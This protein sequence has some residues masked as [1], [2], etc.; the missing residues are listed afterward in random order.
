[1]AFGSCRTTVSCVASPEV[2]ARSGLSWPIAGAHP[3]QA[4]SESC[5]RSCWPDGRRDLLAWSL[6][7]PVRHRVPPLFSLPMRE[8]DRQRDEPHSFRTWGRSA[9]CA[10]VQHNV[11][12]GHPDRRPACARPSRTLAT[13][14]GQ[15]RRLS[16]GLFPFS[17]IRRRC[18]VRGCHYPGRSRCGVAAGRGRRPNFAQS[19]R[20]PAFPSAH[21]CG[22][23]PG[24]TGSDV[25]FPSSFACS[26]PAVGHSPERPFQPGVPVLMRQVCAAWVSWTSAH[27][28][29][30]FAALL[31]PDSSATSSATEAHVS[32]ACR[33][34]L[35]DFGRGIGRQNR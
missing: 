21:S 25:W 17:V 19:S 12:A 34:H 22:F 10:T 16:W 26:P 24:V 18:A 33:I 9:C 20:I 15:G 1:V 31:R 5:G 7:H 3:Q 14:T 23:P 13:R 32:S 11:A 30:P 8:H 28:I 2:R 35:D 29:Q 6:C 4:L 27:G